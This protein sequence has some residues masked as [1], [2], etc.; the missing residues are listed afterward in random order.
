M[1]TM[2]EPVVMSG[3]EGTPEHSVVP[4]HGDGH[5]L[6]GDKA[7]FRRDAGLADVRLRTWVHSGAGVGVA[8]KG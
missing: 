2:D 6:N 5:A 7:L 3:V 8:E 4:L 1:G